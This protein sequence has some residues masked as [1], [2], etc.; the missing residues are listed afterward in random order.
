MINKSIEHRDIVMIMDAK[1]AME[2]KPPV[3]L[4]GYNFR[5]FE[6]ESDIENWCKIETSVGEFD[7][8][9]DAYKHFQYEF[10][11]H[12]NELKK[13]CIF[14]L[15][16]NNQPIG[17]ST[18]WFSNLDIKNHLHWIAVCPEHQGKGLGKAVSQ[19]AV[20]VCTKH[21][22]NEAIWLGTQTGS[23]VAVTIYNKL[24]FFMT[25][26]PIGYN[27]NYIKDFDRAIKVLEQV[28]TPEQVRNLYI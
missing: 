12:I 19:M 27:S 24:G 1:R 18:G 7:S 6:S 4:D 15:D 28:L 14:I 9:E 5:F 22:P 23:Y 3:L 13:R 2:I 21:N 16:K 11:P 17:T 8:Y 10:S 20:T 26:K 25:N